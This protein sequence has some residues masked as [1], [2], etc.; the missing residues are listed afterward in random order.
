[1]E[2]I[3]RDRLILSY[4]STSNVIYKTEYSRVN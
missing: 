3:G 4:S 2:A 1:V